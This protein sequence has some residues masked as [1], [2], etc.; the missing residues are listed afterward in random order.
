MNIYA[1]IIIVAF[2]LL[3]AIGTLSNSRGNIDETQVDIHDENIS[4]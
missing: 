1:I 2:V 3:M 4:D